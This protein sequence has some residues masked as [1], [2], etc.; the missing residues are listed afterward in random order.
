MR[1]NL[2]LFFAFALVF[3]SIACYDAPKFSDTPEISLVNLQY[4]QRENASEI[5]TLKMTIGFQDGDGN[6]GI[7]KV[8]DKGE[9]VVLHDSP[10]L[11]YLDDAYRPTNN[12]AESERFTSSVYGE[13][14]Y[15]VQHISQ[16]EKYIV[17]KSF[18][19]NVPGYEWLPPYEEPYITTNYVINPTILDQPIED[20]VYTEFNVNNRN[21][22]ITFLMDNGSGEY[23]PIDWT[24]NIPPVYT[25]Y[26]FDGRFTDMNKSESSAPIKGELTNN[27]LSIVGFNNTLIG[28]N[29]VKVQIQVQ[30]RNFNKSNIVESEPFRLRDIKIN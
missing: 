7:N 24:K 12:N 29:L 5:D 13:K 17:T 20:T 28:N 8:N 1:T 4:Y 16:S 23:T 25:Q 10:G 30:D 2:N 11:T 19:T 27:V 3:L 18:K 22:Y 14:V 6:L 15:Y 9:T 21:F 26:P